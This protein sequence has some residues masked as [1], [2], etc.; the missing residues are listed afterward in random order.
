MRYVSRVGSVTVYVLYSYQQEKSSTFLDP[1]TDSRGKV[2]HNLHGG[3]SM[4]ALVSVT[5]GIRCHNPYN[6]LKMGTMEVIVF[7]FSSSSQKG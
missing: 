6:L 5:H 2:C 7:T 3:S 1:P 4:S